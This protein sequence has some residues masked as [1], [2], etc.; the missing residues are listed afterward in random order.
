MNDRNTDKTLP[1]DAAY[2]NFFSHPDMVASLLRD[3][4]PE[5]FVADMDFSTLERL[6]GE[7]V[8]KGFARGF[9]DMVWRARWRDRELQRRSG[10]LGTGTAQH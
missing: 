3:F 2:K 1:H 4:V 5:P 8:G 7:Y 6:S 9:S 10:Q